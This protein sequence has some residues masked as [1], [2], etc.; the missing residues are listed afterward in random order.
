LEIFYYFTTF[1]RLFDS[2]SEKEK[3]N[4]KINE[5]KPKKKINKKKIKLQFCY[6]FFLEINAYFEDKNSG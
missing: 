6:A 3:E 1:F 2:K 4:L 5:K